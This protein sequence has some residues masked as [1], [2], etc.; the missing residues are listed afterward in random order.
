MEPCDGAYG[1]DATVDAPQAASVESAVDGSRVKA[2]LDELCPSHNTVLASS[3]RA[4]RAVG[5]R[6]A[7]NV[8]LS[9]T[10][11]RGLG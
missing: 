8:D 11:R 5:T 7:N 4:D 1:V 9:L 6:R 10:A 2:E 3:E